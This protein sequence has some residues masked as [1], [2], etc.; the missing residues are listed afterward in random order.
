[1]KEGTPWDS[2]SHSLDEP[3]QQSGDPPVIATV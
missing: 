2:V 1:L 3:K